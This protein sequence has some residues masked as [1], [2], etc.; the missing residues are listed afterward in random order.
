[1]KIN[2]KKVAASKGYKSLKAAYEKDVQDAHRTI[3]KGSR[4]MRNK[5]TFRKHFQWVIERAK[6]YANHYGVPLEYILYKWEEERD[7]WWLNFYQDSRQPKFHSNSK[8]YQGLR[9]YKKYIKQRIKNGSLSKDE[10]RKMLQKNLPLYN[11]SEKKRWN[12]RVRKHSYKHYVVSC[13]KE[14]FKN[15]AEN[16]YDIYSMPIQEAGQELLDYDADMP[17]H[18][19]RLFWSA[20]HEVM[21]L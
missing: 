19:R 21:N 15:A 6:H 5:E 17:K 20:L 4:P 11:K 8:K 13:I 12:S 16:G 18:D 1:M 10:A 9:G 3:D 2:W 7:Y 14:A